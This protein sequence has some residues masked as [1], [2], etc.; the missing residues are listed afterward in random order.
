MSITATLSQSRLLEGVDRNTL[1]RMA[2]Q[3]VVRHYEP[4]QV[5]VRQGDAATA[6]YILLSGRVRVDRE[7]NGVSE[8]IVDIGPG[9]FF[10]EMALI[11]DHPRTAS[12]TAIEPTE[13][14]LIVAWEFTALMHEYPSIT[15]A[16]LRE[17][18]TRIHRLEHHVF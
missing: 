12:V 4:G 8:H 17:V 11:E 5:I 18:I 9:A 3:A 10:G 1:A 14:M 13:C 7:H 6:V 16:L 15:A 2:E